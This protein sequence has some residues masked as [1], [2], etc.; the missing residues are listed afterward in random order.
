MSIDA[1][2]IIVTF[3]KVFVDTEKRQQQQQQQH[4]ESVV[5]AASIV[6]QAIA[7]CQ[8]FASPQALDRYLTIDVVVSSSSHSGSI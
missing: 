7:E 8:N 4:L 5:E 2:T 1:T 3:S 6:E